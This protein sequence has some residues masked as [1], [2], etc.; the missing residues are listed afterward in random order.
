MLVD[1][2]QIRTSLLLLSFL[3]LGDFEAHAFQVVQ[4]PS[5]GTNSVTAQSTK[6]LPFKITVVYSPK[7]LISL[8]GLEKMHPFDIKKYQSIHEQLKTDGLLTD[9]QTLRPTT[10]SLSLIHISEPTRP[11]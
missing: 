9:E 1:L 5:T 6:E 4:Q 10:L 3:L 8:G 11:Y 7:Y 2:R